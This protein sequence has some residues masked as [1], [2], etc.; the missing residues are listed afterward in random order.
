MLPVR[1]LTRMIEPEHRLPGMVGMT[2]SSTPQADAG[3]N[4]IVSLAGAAPGLPF[5]AADGIDRLG[6][7]AQQ[8]LSCLP[9]GS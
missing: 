2:S 1:P 9:G 3:K 4:T 8:E 5:Q 7:V 6:V